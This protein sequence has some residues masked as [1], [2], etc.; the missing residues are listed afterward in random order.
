LCWVD[1]SGRVLSET[2]TY[3]FY[4]G[5]DVTIRACYS[6]IPTDTSVYV[7]FK[8]KSGKILT[9]EYV[10][11]ASD[12]D[13]GVVEVPERGNYVG[14]TFT[15]WQDEDGNEYTVEDGKV[16]VTKDVTITA[17]YE[18]ITGLTVTVNGTVLDKTYSYGDTVTVTAE[19]SQ[20]NHYFS[21]WYSNE[22]LVS[23][24]QTYTFCVTSDTVLT[25]M[26]QGE[27][28]LKQQPMAN[29]SL[30]DRTTLDTGKQTL[31]MVLSWSLPEGYTFVGA[32]TVRTLVD[33]QK[34]NLSLE[35]VDGSSIKKT[36][37]TLTSSSGAYRCT[38]TL[39]TA[40]VSKNLYAVGY[41]TYKED[42]TGE[43]KTIYTDVATSK[44]AN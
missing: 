30:T 9:S 2:E 10:T 39:S 18:A 4:L 24:S 25:A 32:G 7:I 19:E 37:T 20:D 6:L 44:A 26:Y 3:S 34:G 41:L 22:K 5:E 16:H 36:T 15:G 23:D 43:V 31:Q 29:F 42:D 28:V 27:E 21:G 17:V 8:D 38:V 11:I 35:N 12:S 33:A 1:E 14:Y 13:Y 40:S